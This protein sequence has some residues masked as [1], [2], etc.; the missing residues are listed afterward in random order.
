MAVAQL[1]IVRRIRTDMSYKRPVWLLLYVS[2]G[3]MVLGY[4]AFMLSNPD[5]AGP[6]LPW[7]IIGFGELFM[8]VGAI[9]FIVA[10]IWWLIAG[11]I[12]SVRSH[13]SGG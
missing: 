8:L 3:E 6:A 4:A 5:K 11:I 12:S 13:H 9:G 1:W 2:L 10:V 7:L